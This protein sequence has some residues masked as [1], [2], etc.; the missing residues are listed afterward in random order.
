MSI[1]AAAQAA[2]P[3]AIGVDDAGTSYVGFPSGAVKRYNVGSGTD[4]GAW[5]TQVANADGK[6]G[7]I[8]G[9]DVEPAG[10]TA[11]G[12]DVWILDGNRRVQEFTRAG[13]FIR[14]FRLDECDGGN[15]HEPGVEGGLDVTADAIYVAHPCAD[16]IF[17]YTLG[18]LPATGTSAALPAASQTVYSPHGIAAQAAGG[19]APVQTRTLYVAQSR[20]SVVRQ[21]D[22][23][24]LALLGNAPGG[25]LGGR[26][27]DVF[28]DAAGVLF[29][30]E[31]NPTPG[32][33]D[34]I[35]QYDAD[36]NEIRSLG[37]PGTAQGKL[38]DAG[39]LDVFPQAGVAPGNIFV[40]DTGN[41]RIQRMTDEGF[42]F[43]AA[44]ASDPGPPSAP[45]VDPPPTGGGGGTGGTG[46]T[47]LP[48]G[49]QGGSA[50]ATGAPGVAIADGARYTNTPYVQLTVREPAGTTGLEISN[51]SAFASKDTRSLAGS[52]TYDWTLDE[53][54]SDLT[55]RTVYVRF[56]GSGN[57]G[58]Y[59]DEIILD[60]KAPLVGGA[61][62]SRE[63]KGKKRRW[64]LRVIA[65]DAT[66]GLAELMV[67][68]DNRDNYKSQPFDSSVTVKTAARAQ[69]VRVSD[70]AGNISIPLAV[71]RR[72]R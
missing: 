21:F 35:Y 40:A 28:I 17:R 71:K 52:L 59:T 38:A 36:G 54:A 62:V 33:D 67:A 29:Q 66:S 58:T 22:L 4:L 72:G 14:G 23:T 7:P 16:R 13:A 37:G 68:G 34:L 57:D 50:G 24:S 65:D 32:Y 19:V 1:P 25:H 39:A 45:P 61:T 41:E 8:A 51:T 56:P 5:T 20:S 31:Q 69:F 43:W 42:S 27:D 55:P 12:G 26:Y 63:R 11:N 6:L 3:T 53:S 46:G 30:L 70:V 60:R 48:S 49:G 2:G 10:V 44:A 15:S 64:V 47:T 9:I 18:S